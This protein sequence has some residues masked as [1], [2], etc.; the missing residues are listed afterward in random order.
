MWLM[1]APQAQPSSLQ[2]V[3]SANYSWMSC[4]FADM[5][6]GNRFL[7]VGGGTCLSLQEVVGI[8]HMALIH[9]LQTKSFW[10]EMNPQDVVYF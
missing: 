6:C 3:S 7:S 5:I 1:R 8:K 2:T 4:R 10:L 9:V